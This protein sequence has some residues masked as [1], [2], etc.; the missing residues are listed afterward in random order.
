MTLPISK[1]VLERTLPQLIHIEHALTLDDIAV[2]LF[3]ALC[4]AGYFCNGRLWNKPNPYDH[5]WYERP[6]GTATSTS[7]ATRDISKKMSD[8]SG[9]AEGFANRLAR[10][11]HSRFSLS[12]M[13]ADLSDY[14]PSTIASLSEKQYLV[15]ILSTYGEG[16]PSDNTS[17]IWNWLHQTS[18]TSLGN[19]RYMAFGLGNSSYKF[20]NRVVDVIVDALDKRGAVALLP[21]GKADDCKGGTEEDFMTWKEKV[22]ECFREKLNLQEQDFQYEPKYTIENMLPSPEV[23]LDSG[24]PFW[25]PEHR[26]AADTYSPIR[27]LPVKISKDLLSTSQRS[28]LH[29]EL[30]LSPYPELK[31]RTGDHL[32]VWP[33]NPDAEVDLLLSVLGFEDRKE[34]VIR[35]A[36]TDVS[37][38]NKL[39]SITTIEALFRYHLDICAP[40]SRETILTLCHFAPSSSAQEFLTQLG[41]SKIK[42][43]QVQKTRQITMGRLLQ[44][45]I[46]NSPA[47]PWSTIPFSFILETLPLMMPRYYSISSSSIVSPRQ[48]SITAMVSVT[49]LAADAITAPN[50]LSGERIFGLATNYLLA[51]SRFLHPEA[52]TIQPDLYALTYDLEGP[53][54]VLEGAKIHA[55]IRRSKFKL[56][57]A[58]ASP[59][60][61]IA[62]GTGVAPFRA[63]LQECARLK[64]LGKAVGSMQLFFGCR[65]EEEDFL[66]QEELMRLQEELGKGTL[67]IVTAFSR[68]KAG[69][70]IYVQDRVMENREMVYEMLM[71]KD[72]TLYICGSAAMGR[73]VAAVVGKIVRERRQW[74]DQELKG[75]MEQR[76]KTRR[77]QEDMWA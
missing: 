7:A 37:M 59:L 44:L 62:A 72:A 74:N 52:C 47:T 42:Y 50:D 14:D 27:T 24:E 55:M 58:P 23:L 68:E 40:V 20:Y 41:K 46:Q 53:N 70:K 31:Y 56:P 36:L 39:P 8:A 22:L 43:A 6:Q 67:Q 32:A 51:L 2:L 3:I 13:A 76:K 29:M 21:V 66:Y 5:L 30:D 25:R 63:F 4:S 15:F 45:A 49:Q 18:Q 48:P 16:D 57:A 73:E 69:E 9:T 77:W 26:K 19:V 33:I 38:R 11:C 60:I 64:T 28:C 61:M 1:V 54:K 75:W 35:I 12:A 65:R 71:E 10:E 17:G 34:K